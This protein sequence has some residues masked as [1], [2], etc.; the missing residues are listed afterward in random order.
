V[1]WS[2]VEGCR[3]SLGP[4]GEEWISNYVQS[5]KRGISYLLWKEG[6]KTGL[7]KK[8]LLIHVIE[9][10]IKGTG[11]GGRIRKQILDYINELRRYWNFKEEVLD[12]IL[13]IH[14]GLGCGPVTQQTTKLMNW[15]H[16]YSYY[17]HNVSGSSCDTISLS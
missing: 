16:N 8:Y 15:T 3:R 17:Y 7:R 10:N 1:K 6:R 13:R 14:F 5:R 2:S 4:I 11:R 9:G 12:R